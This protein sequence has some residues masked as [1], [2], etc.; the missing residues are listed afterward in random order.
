MICREKRRQEMTNE[1]VN[2]SARNFF[3]QYGDQ[4]SQRNI[5]GKLLKFSKG[6]YTVGQEGEEVPYGTRFAVDMDK[7]F[8]IGWIKWVDGKPEEEIMGLLSEGFSPP[9]R[10]E[11]SDTDESLWERDEEGKARDPWQPT[12]KVL[13]KTPGKKRVGDDHVYTFSTSSFGG[14]SNLG[15]L[16]KA[17]GTEMRARPDQNPIVEIGMEK[18]KHSNTQYGII[19]NPTFTIVGW[20]KKSLFDANAE[21]AP[22]VA[23]PKKTRR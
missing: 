21:E 4:T 14:I 8:L 17:Y 3:E 7:G 13:F 19:K 5:I 1:V 20:E 18:Y 23:L 9:K 16:S 6:D 12:N 2:P 15:K 11:L 22:V 10:R